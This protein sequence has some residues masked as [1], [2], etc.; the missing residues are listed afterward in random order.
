MHLHHLFGLCTVYISLQMTGYCRYRGLTM[1]KNLWEQKP[2]FYVISKFY[3]RSALKAIPPILWYWPATSEVD[4]GGTAVEVE[5]SANTPLCFAAMWQAAAERQS[6][7]MVSDMEMWMKQRCVT[8]SLHAEKMTPTDIHQHLLYFYGDQAVDVSTVSSGWCVSAAGIV[9]WNTSHVPVGHV[10][11][12]KQ[13]M[14]AL[15]HCCWKWKV[16][17]RDYVEK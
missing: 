9:M 16:N 15:V 1:K 17:G 4:I 12:Y 13:D 6:D 8:E 2:D 14:Q 3:M 11:F 5:P 7:R 10:D